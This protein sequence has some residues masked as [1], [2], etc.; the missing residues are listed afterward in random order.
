MYADFD[1]RNAKNSADPA[2]RTAKYKT[3]FQWAEESYRIAKAASATSPW[4]SS[5]LYY[6]GR[7][8]LLQG[9]TNEAM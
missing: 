5:A 6:M 7:I 3:A 1:I 9:E 8:K 2:I 4:V